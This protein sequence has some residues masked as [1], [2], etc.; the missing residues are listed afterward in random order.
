MFYPPNYHRALKIQDAL[1][2]DAVNP[3]TK[4]SDRAQLARAW[5]VLEDR[6]RIIRMIPAPKPADAAVRDKAKRSAPKGFSESPD[7]PKA[8]PIV[9]RDTPSSSGAAK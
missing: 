6:K 7:S 3:N 1:Y 5:D 4:P 8:K 2:A 9:P